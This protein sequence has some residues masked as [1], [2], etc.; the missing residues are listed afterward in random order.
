MVNKIIN[1]LKKNKKTYLILALIILLGLALRLYNLG[2]QSFWIDEA[3]SVRETQF[4]LG[5]II[6]G[7]DP[8]PP[9][10]YSFLF[11]WTRMFGIS[12]FNVRLLSVIFSIISI[13]IFYLLGN[14]IFKKK[15]SNG[16]FM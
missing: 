3:Y 2:E 13:G 6:S 4:S 15:V 11:F 16:S 14:F 5:R 7:T 8:T 1:N 9:L 10:Y 12:E